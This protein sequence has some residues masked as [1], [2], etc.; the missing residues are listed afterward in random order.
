MPVYT[1]GFHLV[2]DTIEELHAFADSIGMKRKWFQ[3]KRKPHYDL[4]GRKADIAYLK[5]AEKVTDRECVR[6][7][8]D[9]K[10]KM[11]GA[12]NRN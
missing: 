5:G 11:N 9:C 10:K 4:F 3:D 7:A 6:I 8:N 1:D 12:P 2:A